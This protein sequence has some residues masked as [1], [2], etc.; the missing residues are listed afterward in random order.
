MAGAG[1]QSRSFRLGQWQ[2]IQTAILEQLSRHYVDTLPV[3]AMRSAGI[4]AMLSVLDPYTVYIPEEDNEDLQMM[5]ART[6][7]GIGAVI[8]KPEKS[9]YVTIN[10][11]YEGSPAARAGLVCG[12]E[13]MQIDGVDVR[14]LDASQCS[15]RMKGKPGTT[16][17]FKVKRVRGG[18]VETI[19]VKRER[20]HIPDM[21][22]AGMLDG[23]DGYILLSGFSENASASV[24]NAVRQL[25]DSGMKR[26]FLDLR[27][28][29]G[30]LLHEAVGIVSIFVPKGSLVVTQKGGSEPEREYRTTVEPVDTQMP[31]TV[32]IDGA[33]ASSSE[34]VAG[35][36]QDMDR[37]VIAGRRSFGKGLVQS[38]FPLPYNGQLKVTTSKYYTPSGRCVQAIDYSSRNADGSTG[39]IPDSLTHEFRTAGGRIVRDGGGITPDRELKGPDYSPVTISLVRRGIITDYVLKYV[40]EHDSIAPEDVF[41]FNDYDDFV[42]FCSGREF[43]WRS[44]AKAFFDKMKAE[45]VKEGT[46][47]RLKPQLDALEDALSISKED[48]L[49]L[50]KDEILPYIEEEIAVRYYFQK[51]GVK[52]RLRYDSVLLQA[53]G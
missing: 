52:V 20:I 19:P 22:Y 51:A 48:M 27:G 41:R 37:A 23:S 44:G 40:R 18:A 21:E 8:Y 32:L 2:E 6:Y 42:K 7:G 28:N 11:P 53:R 38:I 13:I 12:D 4:E 15:E 16:V 9:A 36:L 43:D 39:H 14:G 3:S 31:V 26:L 49:Q 30:G 33:S 10:E 46:D 5:L 25:K 50:R 47:G 29:G 34:I 17:K 1:A 35:A 45:L 24:R